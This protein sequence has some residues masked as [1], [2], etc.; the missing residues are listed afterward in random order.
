[1]P[2]IYKVKSP[3]SL[4]QTKKKRWYLNL[5]IYRNSHYILLNNMK[6][7]YPRLI[8]KQVDA[9][10]VFTTP[11]MVK[12]V[13]Y[14]KDKRLFDL[15]N[16]CCIHSKFFLDTLVKSKKIPDDNYKIVVE[17]RIAFGEVDPINPRVQIYIK[18]IEE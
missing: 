7:L 8:Q 1:M 5:N 13:V 15:M 9:L 4:P 3:L 6:V 18:P 11:I 14:P 16:V 2:K 10:P 17:E 12:Y